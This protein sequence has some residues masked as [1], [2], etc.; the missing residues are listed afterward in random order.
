MHGVYTVL[1][2]G[3]IAQGRRSLVMMPSTRQLPVPEVSGRSCVNL[4]PCMVLIMHGVYAVSSGWDT[5][6]GSRLP[7]EIPC[8]DSSNRTFVVV[9]AWVVVPA[10][11]VADV[12]VEVP[13]VVCAPCV[14]C[15]GQT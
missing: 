9:P 12:E 3:S 5:Q 4:I 10:V 2:T 1:L 7:K 13:A 6:V 14:G 11:L 8:R 15:G